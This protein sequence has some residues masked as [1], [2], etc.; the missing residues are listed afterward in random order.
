MQHEDPTDCFRAR[1]QHQH[2]FAAGS[3]ANEFNTTRLLT[4]DD[5]SVGTNNNSSPFKIPALPAHNEASASNG[6]ILAYSTMLQASPTSAA[7]KKHQDPEVALIKTL[8]NKH[9]KPW[10]EITT[11]PNNACLKR[12]E[13]LIW[14]STS[15][16]SAYV[17]ATPLTAAPTAEMGLT[18]KD[19]MHLHYPNEAG[20]PAS[21]IHSGSANPLGSTGGVSKVAKKRVKDWSNIKELESNVRKTVGKEEEKDELKMFETGMLLCEAKERVERNFWVL[22]GDEMERRRAR[23]Y[24]AEGLERRWKEMQGRSEG[25][26]VVDGS[27]G[28]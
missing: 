2:V 16:Y 20:D 11:S 3:L 9:S 1:W 17:L 24:S 27:D 13:P 5:T 15:F 26:I 14:T 25:S 23:S 21:I 4:S 22:V 28:K 12:S 6:P 18:P 7:T 10:A 8:R 19:Y